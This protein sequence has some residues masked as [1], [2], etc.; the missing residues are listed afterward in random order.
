MKAKKLAMLGTV[1]SLAV[2]LSVSVANAQDF[3]SWLQSI[4]HHQ[5]AITQTCYNK[6]L[7]QNSTCG[8]T[9]TCLN[10]QS[11][12]TFCQADQHYCSSN[13]YTG[14]SSTLQPGDSLGPVGSA[15]YSVL[16][17][18][19]TTA[20]TTTITTTTTTTAP[21]PSIKT[22][23]EVWSLTAGCAQSQFFYCPSTGYDYCEMYYAGTKDTGQLVA[24]CDPGLKCSYSTGPC[25]GDWHG[26]GIK[27]SYPT[28]PGTIPPNAISE[29]LNSIFNSIRTW[30][31][32]NLFVRC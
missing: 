32:C 20:I 26:Y 10:L 16:Y 27:L 30:I 19:L 5:F 22:Y 24:T 6:R 1:I 29:I 12:E 8:G 15:R 14:A 18:C 11:G 25:S 7:I 3:F 2:F 23:T 4:F 31:N 21:S 17:G 9:I 13:I 28:P